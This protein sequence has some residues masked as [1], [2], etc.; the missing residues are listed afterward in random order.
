MVLESVHTTLVL[1]QVLESLGAEEFMLF[2][3]FLKLQPDPIPASR[4]EN[5]S[6]TKTVDLMVQHYHHEGARRVTKEILRTIG[7]HLLA[8]QLW[9]SDFGSYSP[10]QPPRHG[11]GTS[12]G[13]GLCRQRHGFWFLL[14]AERC[15]CFDLRWLFY[16][17]MY[18]IQYGEKTYYKL[19]LL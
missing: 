12:T 3:Y 14:T 19:F 17:L 8:D 11:P 10:T 9:S 5:A 1:L 15:C 13:P 7:F 2:Q 6:R 4:L 16:C 18:L